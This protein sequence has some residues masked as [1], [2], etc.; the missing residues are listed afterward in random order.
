MVDSKSSQLASNCTFPLFDT[1]PAPSRGPPNIQ[2]LCGR[3]RKIY[4]YMLYPTST[5]IYCVKIR[6]LS[7]RALSRRSQLLPP[8]QRCMV[9]VLS[10]TSLPLLNMSLVCPAGSVPL[11][12]QESWRDSRGRGCRVRVDAC[13]LLPLKDIL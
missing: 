5:W 12:G 3:C 4:S 6:D 8:S 1:L 7:E 13:C 10:D 2:R 9:M 11:C